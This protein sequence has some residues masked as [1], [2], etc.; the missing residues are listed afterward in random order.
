MLKQSSSNDVCSLDKD[1]GPCRG[2]IPRFFFNK[3]TKKCEEFS[4]GGCLGNEN[5]FKNAQEC[6]S[7]CSS[8]NICELEKDQGPCRATLDRFY[9]NKSTQKCEKFTY[10]GCLGNENNFESES[11]CSK[12]CSSNSKRIILAQNSKCSQKFD[13]G[14]CKLNVKRYFY[15][16]TS[17]TCEEFIY[18]G[19]LGS[20]NNFETKSECSLSCVVKPDVC[21]L[22]K[23]VGPCRAAVKRFFFNQNTKQCEEF[24]FGGCQG[25]E[26]NFKSQSECQEKCSSN[27][28]SQ[29]VQDNGICSL[30]KEQGP[31]RGA[32]KKFFFNP[33]TNKCEQF[34]YGGCQG[35]ENNFENETDCLKR[36]GSSLTKPV[37]EQA[38]NKCNLP[39]D[40][41]PCFAAFQRYFY[42]PTLKRCQQFTYGGCQGNANNF[43]TEEE[44][45]SECVPKLSE[46]KCEQPLDVG[47]CMA[48]FKRYF[49]NSTTKSCEEFIFGI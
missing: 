22:Q 33:A 45:K 3:Q 29:A 4:Y 38:S 15:N 18:G 16:S 19:C 11:E 17:N 21:T 23:D 10:G 37:I 44:C 8:N 36:C 26:N 39:M 12:K 28:V 40:V 47:P 32:F 25:N 41:G 35:N 20:E 6:N 46:N 2:A 49:Y 5:N 9:F 42:N 13:I 24:I 1:I 34:I 27:S 43:K 30:K 7:K 14:A 31:C 48:A